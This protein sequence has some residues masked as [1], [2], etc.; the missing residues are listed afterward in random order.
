MKKPLTAPKVDHYIHWLRDVRY[1]SSDIAYTYD[2]KAYELLSEVYE[3]LG[4]IVPKIAY[5]RKVWN[6]WFKADRGHI[7]DFGSF[8]D[9]HE[10]GSVETREEFENWWRSSYPDETKWYNF[11]ALYDEE[12]DYRAIDVGYRFVIE[13]DPR[14]SKSY[15]HDISEFAEWIRDSIKECIVGIRDGSYNEMIEKELPPQ[16]KTGT[17]VR[18]QYWDIFPDRR[19]D[20]FA[21][22]PKADVADFLRI[23][24]PQHEPSKDSIGRMT[25]FTANDFFECCSIGYKAIGFETE[26]L[27]PKEQYHRHADGRDEGLREI[28]PDSA[29]AY[30]AWYDAP[31]RGGGHPWEVCRGGNS[32]HIS[33]YVH[34]DDGGAYLH[35]AGSAVTR[36]IESVK[37]FLAL[38]RAGKPTLIQD[39]P[40]LAARLDESEKIGIVPEGVFPSYCSSLFPD[41][42]IIAFINLPEEK[43]DEVARCCVWQP[44]MKPVLVE[45]RRSDEQ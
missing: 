40:R 26:G 11:Q 43:R 36:T 28:D 27:T 44:I 30:R 45:A 33:L 7:E 13:W 21:D 2:P 9:L 32:T 23:M 24:K 18:R 35:I 42:K 25:R 14:K 41:E 15:E 19:E 39:A 8:D 1:M 31:Q 17:I 5:G 20:F 29:E 22:I 10:E 4:K 6:L 37:F 16:H 34:F 38:H 3:L 12:I